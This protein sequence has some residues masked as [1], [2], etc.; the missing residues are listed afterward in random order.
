MMAHV[1]TK[2]LDYRMMECPRLLKSKLQ[3]K[4]LSRNEPAAPKL[5]RT[6][7][8]P[9]ALVG[10]PKIFKNFQLPEVYAQILAEGA[11]K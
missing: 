8:M 3:R 2:I 10:P 5:H 1:S 9:P 7:E 11:P 4:H 6:A